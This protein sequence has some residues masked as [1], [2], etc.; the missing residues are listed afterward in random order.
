MNSA[1]PAT[2]AV[3][4]LVLLV[5]RFARLPGVVAEGRRV[6]AHERVSKLFLS[7]TAYS[8]AVAV[9]FGLLNLQFPSCPANCHS[10]TA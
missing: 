5:G 7:K 8:I 2:K 4:R 10:R 3:A 9:S 1:A 6:I